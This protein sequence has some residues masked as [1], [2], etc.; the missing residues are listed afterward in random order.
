[1][2][3]PSTPGGNDC[4]AAAVR[5][6]NLAKR[7]RVFPRPRDRLLQA[8]FGARRQYFREFHAL[9]GVSFEVAH[10]R[11]VGIVGRNGSGKSTLL[12]IIAGTLTPTTGE[13]EIDGNVAA[14]LELGSGFNPEFTGR[15]NVHLNASILGLDA[16]TLAERFDAIVAFADIGDFLDQPVK[17]YSSGMAVRLA[18][19]VAMSVDPRILIVDEALSVG[20]EAFQRKCFARIRQLKEGGA[21]ILFVS[22]SASAVVELCDEAI[23]LD[24]GEL[25]L[26]GDPKRVVAL[27]QKL[28]YAPPQ[29]VPTLRK[30]IRDQGPQ[31]AAKDG[32]VPQAPAPAA[33]AAAAAGSGAPRPL[34]DP[35]LM[36]ASAVDYARQGAEICDVRIETPAGEQVN[37]LVHGERYAYA[38][39]VRFDRTLQRVQFGMLVKTV[40]GLELGGG[41]YPS[42]QSCFPLVEAGELAEVRFE[43]RCLVNPGTYFLNAGVQAEVDGRATYVHRVVDVAMF[44]VLPVSAPMATAWVNL[45]VI[46]SASLRAAG[47]S[48]VS[49]QTLSRIDE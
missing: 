35:H 28:I 49:S 39:R 8:M 33:A 9:S 40:S 29:A 11:T 18:F 46:P 47:G 25:L 2:T 32:S 15:E 19:A 36:S 16:A 42:L 4:Q 41:I 38:Y 43:F 37:I 14:L 27:Y 17:T 10:G 13:V 31:P 34:F 24:H 30:E 22:H 23:L 5:V 6:T 26:R 44:K 21:T 20:D 12:Q 1:M 7:Y 3:N 48:P 45:D